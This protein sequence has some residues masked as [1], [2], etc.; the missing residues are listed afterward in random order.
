MGGRNV[1]R[2]ERCWWGLVL[3]YSTALVEQLLG[4]PTLNLSRAAVTQSGPWVM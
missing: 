4:T 1:I 3:I 2:G